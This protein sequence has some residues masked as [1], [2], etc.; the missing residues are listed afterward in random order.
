MNFCEIQAPLPQ[1][2]NINRAAKV[3]HPLCAGLRAGTATG[4]SNLFA[5]IGGLAGMKDFLKRVTTPD[6]LQEEDPEARSRGV[7]AVGPPGVGKSYGVEYELD[8][9]GLFEKISGKFFSYEQG[10]K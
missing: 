5:N 9:A 7:T 4:F 10:P 3:V 1:A 6:S 8:K 2:D